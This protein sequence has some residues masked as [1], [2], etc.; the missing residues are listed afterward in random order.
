M[1]IILLSYLLQKTLA[2]KSEDQKATCQI[3]LVRAENLLRQQLSRPFHEYHYQRDDLNH[4]NMRQLTHQFD[5]GS[6][7]LP[8]H[9]LK[10][11]LSLILL[12]A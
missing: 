6:F 7:L 4:Y 2:G 11:H 12:S 5:H 10:N 1:I 3:I 8:G 9:L